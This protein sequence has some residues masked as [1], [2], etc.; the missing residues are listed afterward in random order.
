MNVF[1]LLTLLL[2]LFT[3]LGVQLFGKTKYLDPTGPHANFHDFWRGCITLIRCMTG[4]GFNEMMHALSRNAEY[5]NTIVGEPCYEQK[6][7]D[8]PN[9]DSWAILKSKCL[10]DR[11]NGCSSTSGHEVAYLFWITYTWVITFVILNLVIAVI[12]EG[13]DDSSKNE[14]GEV[15][16]N[17]ILMWKKHDKAQAL[18]LDLAHALQFI[19]DVCEFYELPKLDCG[20]NQ[21]EMNR[22][23]GQRN[24]V[25]NIEEINMKKIAN[26]KMYVSADQ[27]VH[28]VHAMQW[29]VKMVMAQNN[30]DSLNDIEEIEEKDPKIQAMIA[31]QEERQKVDEILQGVAI[32]ISI[33]VATL[34]IQ[35]R[36][37]K[38]LEAAR[39]RIKK[40]KEEAA[41]ESAKPRVAG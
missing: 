32:D 39:E 10:I 8:Y 4:E 27:Q 24:T 41:A 14:E 33:Q 31:K 12:L 7:L 22:S 28:L 9:E 13:F 17:C 30:P 2:F 3:V 34:K 26:C 40:A 16:D 36:L 38:K 1:V 25:M 6:L 21:D 5:F 20:L 18:V 35:R 37:K 29:A 11:P 15:V 23:E 19:D